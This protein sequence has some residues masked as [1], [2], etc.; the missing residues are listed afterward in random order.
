MQRGGDLAGARVP[1]P[2]SRTASADSEYVDS[3]TPV[4]PVLPARNAAGVPS[5]MMRPPAS[6]PSGPHFDQPVGGA[7]H[8]EVVFDDQQ[9]MPA[10]GELA[11]GA[12]Q[13]RDVL[14]V[15]SGGGFVED[16]Q[17]PQRGFG[18]G[19]MAGEF[20]ALRFTA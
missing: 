17:L 11:E 9:R 10:R 4:C 7:D 5:A 3:A 6:P 2:A 8:I 16:Q 13:L 20:Q 19:Q 12:H 1:G 14:E 15:Q 18:V